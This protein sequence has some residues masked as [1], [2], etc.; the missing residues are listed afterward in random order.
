MFEQVIK[1][2]SDYTNINIVEIKED[3]TLTADLDLSSLDVVSIVT[4]FEDQFG[5]EIPDREIGKFFTV[6]DIL[7]YL[8]AHT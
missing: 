6:G 2:L 5:I 3:S 7:R 1:I 4:E 8:E